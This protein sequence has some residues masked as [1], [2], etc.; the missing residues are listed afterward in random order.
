MKI[1]LLKSVSGLGQAGEIK[2]VSEGY[3]RNYLIPK[4]LADL[5]TKH[6][7]GIIDAQK[8]K[9]ARTNIQ[10]K[11]NKKKLAK[12]LD[13]KLITIEAKADDNDTLYAGI[14]SKLLAMEMQA[15]GHKVEAG[16]IK[17]GAAIKKLG[18]HKAEL[19]LGGGK[20]RI[21]VKVVKISE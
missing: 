5:V 4:D 6:S 21:K 19:K 11:L 10:E 15:Q 13:R 2:N 12:K 16:E 14:T 3:A 20:A 18:E 8:K 9:R 17:L 7:L 1:V